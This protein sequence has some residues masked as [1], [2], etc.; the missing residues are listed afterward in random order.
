VTLKALH[1]DT[2]VVI[3]LHGG[4]TN[5]LPAA[6]RARLSSTAPAISPMVLV[7]LDLLHGIGRVTESAL[8]VQQ[9]LADSI[10][11]TIAEQSFTAVARAASAL[12]WTRDPFDRVI[13]AQSIAADALLLTG[14]QVIRAHLDRAR[15]SEEDPS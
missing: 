3:W 11:L 1:L 12:S 5:L 8:V 15:W 4:A 2:H 13:A 14:D 7:E 10:G 6:A 9:S